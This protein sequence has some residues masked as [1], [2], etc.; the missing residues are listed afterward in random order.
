MHTKRL[1]HYVLFSRV[2]FFGWF[3][4]KKAPARAL[5]FLLWSFLLVAG[6]LHSLSVVAQ[7]S[8]TDAGRVNPTRIL[9]VG[10]SLSAEYGLRRGTGW[11]QLLQ[12]SLAK[13]FSQDSLIWHNASISGDTTAGGKQRLG[14]LL[15]EHRPDIV[16]LELGGND[17]LRGL[18]LS[19]TESNLQ[20]MI[21]Q[22]KQ[23]GARVILI[24]TQ[25]P[26]N[27][28]KRYTSDYAALFE[29]LATRHKVMR[30]NF[31]LAGVADRADYA[32]YFQADGIHPNEQ[33]QP[34]MANNV[35]PVL[36]KQLQQRPV[37]RQ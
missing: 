10:D 30:V 15:N 37:Q 33:A 13:R 36:E 9:V 22:S 23:Q 6:L 19:Q 3:G 35:L 14:K 16:L 31:L 18:D 29:K 5:I 26:P 27:Y 17:A 12:Q 7:P 34:I 28:G 25:I 4:R 24:G 1:W 8:R 32:S 20:A 11:V 21:E 2:D